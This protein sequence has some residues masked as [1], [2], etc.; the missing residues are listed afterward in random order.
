MSDQ[1]Q[2]EANAK[3]EAKYKPR[4]DVVKKHFEEVLPN[5]LENFKKLSKYPIRVDNG[6]VLHPEI[7]K[8]VEQTY[9]G[10][11]AGNP[12]EPVERE[13]KG[14]SGTYFLRD[15]SGA[16]VSVFKPSD[17]EPKAVNNP[18]QRVQA[19]RE[20]DKDEDKGRNIPSSLMGEITVGLCFSREIAA[21]FLDHPIGHRREGLAGGDVIG[22]AGVPPTMFV[23]CLHH[24][25]TYK[26]YEYKIQNYKEGSLQKY[27]KNEGSL[28]TWIKENAAKN[29]S[30]KLKLSEEEA[31]KVVCNE[32]K[33]V[34]LKKHEQ[35]WKLVK[36]EYKKVLKLIPKEEVHKL[37]VLDIRMTN[38]DRHGGNILV[39]KNETDD[40]IVLIPI[41]HGFSISP[42]IGKSCKFV[43][44]YWPQARVCY[45]DEIKKYINALNVHEDVKLLRKHKLNVKEVHAWVLHVS[46]MLL[47]K[48]VN[49]GLTPSQIG[50]LMCNK[51]NGKTFIKVIVDEA[52]IE[53]H[54]TTCETAFLDNVSGIMD[55]WFKDLNRMAPYFADPDDVLG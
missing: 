19:D 27:M 35:F 32:T 55:A 30:R 22:F 53:P 21:Y 49:E 51:L 33:I 28:A 41:D 47:K 2:R 20:K 13:E 31:I 40:S 14:V 12:P 42:K 26:E 18:D 8:M 37:S 1:I 10:F 9:E 7:D 36:K 46:T 24:K 17:E 52:G 15:S 39:S 16:R 48:G 50:N 23:K 6:E 25:F 34:S 43:W 4:C 44:R 45:S 54:P 38:F 29:I 5:E 11:M 3:R